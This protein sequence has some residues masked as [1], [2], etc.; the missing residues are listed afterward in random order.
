MGMVLKL[1]VCHWEEDKKCH[2]EGMELVQTCTAQLRAVLAPSCTLLGALG[3]LG[4]A[5][6]MLLSPVVPC[7]HSS[8]VIG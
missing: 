2:G 5:L 7:T 6:A 1:S 8:A 4:A 3:A